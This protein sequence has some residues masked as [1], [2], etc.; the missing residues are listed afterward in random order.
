MIGVLTAPLQPILRRSRGETARCYL[1]LAQCLVLAQ[2][3]YPTSV[4]FFLFFLVYSMPTLVP[5]RI[6]YDLFV[7]IHRTGTSLP[8]C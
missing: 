5:L 8:R 1:T 3:L 6:K 2:V 4:V 7:V